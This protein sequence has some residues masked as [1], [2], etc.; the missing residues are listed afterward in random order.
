MAWAILDS[1]VYI[2]YWQGDVAIEEA[3]ASIRQ[4]FVIR[5]SSVVLSELRRGA[6]T[7]AAQHIVEELFALAAVQWCPTEEDWWTAG[8]LIRVIGD[9]HQ[10]DASK[11]RD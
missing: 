6:R 1:N 5:H 4:T 3:L 8:R 9:A 7:S 2:D 10:W 11:R